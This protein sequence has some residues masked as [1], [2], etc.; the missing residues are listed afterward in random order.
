MIDFTNQNSVWWEEEA[1]ESRIEANSVRKK[2]KISIEKGKRSWLEKKFYFSCKMEEHSV[3]HDGK[4][5]L[6]FVSP[7]KTEYNNEKSVSGTLCARDLEACFNASL[8]SS[9]DVSESSEYRPNPDDTDF[10]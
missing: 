10:D 8:A 2:K 4:V 6:K 1:F 5:K 7:G 3:E 9:E